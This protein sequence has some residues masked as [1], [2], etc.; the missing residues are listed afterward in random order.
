MASG[1]LP[2][3]EKVNANFR[4]TFYAFGVLVALGLVL[5]YVGGQWGRGLGAALIL[6]GALGLLVDSF[7][8]RRAEPYTQA[9][10]E[11]AADDSDP[12]T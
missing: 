11:I 12:P 6:I 4:L 7:A 5:H 1:E 3:M 9:L 2:R 8:E 10:Q